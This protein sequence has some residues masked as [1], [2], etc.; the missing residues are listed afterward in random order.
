MLWNLEILK[1]KC[2]FWST[3]QGKLMLTTI[4]IIN[5]LFLWIIATQRHIKVTNL[6]W[7]FLKEFCKFWF[8]KRSGICGWCCNNE[9]KCQKTCSNQKHFFWLK[10]CLMSPKSCLRRDSCFHLLPCVNFI[11]IFT[12]EFFVRTAFQ[13]LFLVTFWLGPKIHTKNESI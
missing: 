5:Y 7:I 11:N 12:Y 6:L 8:R 10:C 1:I 13:Q 2:R 9:I 4:K 3:Y